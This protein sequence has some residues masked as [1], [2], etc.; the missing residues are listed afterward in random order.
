LPAD[1]HILGSSD[2]ANQPAHGVRGAHYL[3]GIAGTASIN[4]AARI[5]HVRAALGIRKSDDLARDRDR[6]AAVLKDIEA[7]VQNRPPAVA[8]ALPHVRDPT[9]HRVAR[10]RARDD[11]PRQHAVSRPA[12]IGPGRPEQ[13]HLK[14]HVLR[15]RHPGKTQNE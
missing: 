13:F 5:I 6:L 7:K 4:W 8:R 12:R 2:A 1:R 3:G 11:D 14:L 15:R 10:E 9:F